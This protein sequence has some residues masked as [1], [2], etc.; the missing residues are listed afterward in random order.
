MNSQ[1]IYDEIINNAKSRG[2][3]KKLLE[4]YYEKHHIVPRCMKGTND[5]DNLVLLT[6]REHYLCHWLL[7]KV[8]TNNK[9]LM[10]AYYMM[11]HCKSEK[12]NYKI[13]SKQYAILRTECS[14]FKSQTQL[15]RKHD[16]A[17]RLKRSI[18]LMGHKNFKENWI[19]SEETKDLISKALKGKKKSEECKKALSESRIGESNPFFGKTHTDEFKNML[20][21]KFKNRVL[22]DEHKLKLSQAAKN[23]YKK[24]TN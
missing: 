14:L 24:L 7:W 9:S 2:L 6:A 5:E 21:K 22:T 3:N 17:S 16:E 4:G 1:R 10:N 19:C 13:S 18:K 20:S 12:R 8:N 15:G 11:T 23:H